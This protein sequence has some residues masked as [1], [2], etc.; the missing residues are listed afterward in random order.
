[1]VQLL[2]LKKDHPYKRSSTNEYKL[3]ELLQFGDVQIDE[4]LIEFICQIAKIFDMNKLAS[5]VTESPILL[6]L[7]EHVD[8]NLDIDLVT[9]FIRDGYSPL[10]SKSQG[11]EWKFSTSRLWFLSVFLWVS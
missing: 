6:V 8:Q 2:N 7:L 5:M 1:M 9:K 11:S 3:A 4:L 10:V